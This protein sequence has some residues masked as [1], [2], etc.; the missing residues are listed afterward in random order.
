MI[1]IQIPASDKDLAN[2]WVR[3]NVDHSGDDTFVVNK[4]D[5]FGNEY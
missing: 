3:D 2:Q 1:Y 4:Q 5:D